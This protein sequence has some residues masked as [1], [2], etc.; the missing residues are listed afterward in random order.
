MITGT[1]WQRGSIEGKTFT[2]TRESVHQM[3]KE[4]AKKESLDIMFL[5]KTEGMGGYNYGGSAG[6]SIMIAPFVKVPDNGRYDGYDFLHGC[7]NPVECQF[8]TFFHELAHCKLTPHVPSIV[9]G[10]SWNDTSRY[11]FEVWITVLGIEYAHRKYG[12]K[13]SD[14]TVQ[15]MLEEAKTYCRP[16]DDY[17]KGLV[18]EEVTEDGY[19]VV[20]QWEFKGEQK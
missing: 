18:S 9:K 5:T 8:A 1:K 7:S 19:K 14:E 13:F 12:I 16:E 3:M 2:W 20:S 6:N 15:W 17:A 10:Y 11:Q 4:I